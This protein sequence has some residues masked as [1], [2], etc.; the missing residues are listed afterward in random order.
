MV[1]QLSLICLG[2][3]QTSGG[4]PLAAF[5]IVGWAE[6]APLRAGRAATRGMLQFL[7]TGAEDKMWLLLSAARV[8]LLSLQR[9]QCF[10][11]NLFSS[12]LKC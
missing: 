1:E 4:R 8:V 5:M 6:V 2:L 7:L 11:I 3:V 10:Q 12:I 9:N